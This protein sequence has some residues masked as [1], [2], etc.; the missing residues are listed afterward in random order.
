MTRLLSAA[1]QAE[2]GKGLAGNCI[3]TD[4][5]LGLQEVSA[6]EPKT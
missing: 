4:A 2:D 1:S 3:A 5:R 6:L